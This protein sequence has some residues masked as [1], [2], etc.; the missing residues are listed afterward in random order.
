AFFIASIVAPVFQVSSG[1]KVAYF[2]MR[3]GFMVGSIVE[4]RP[5]HLRAGGG[6]VHSIKTGPVIHLSRPV[7]PLYPLYSTRRRRKQRKRSMALGKG[8]LL[9][10]EPAG[11]WWPCREWADRR[12]KFVRRPK[13]PW[14][15]PIHRAGRGAAGSRGERASARA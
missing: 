6:A 10:I 8:W 5:W 3:F 11:F 14:G 2:G 7:A 9:S 13:S 12:P 15:C 1:S 4:M